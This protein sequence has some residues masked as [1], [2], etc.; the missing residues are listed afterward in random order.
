MGGATQPV[1]LRVEEPE[2]N[3]TTEAQTGNPAPTLSAV[4]HTSPPF[5][6]LEEPQAHWWHQSQGRWLKGSKSTAVSSAAHI[7]Q[8]CRGQ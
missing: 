5:H 6:P 1:E 2:I 3:A 7:P 8:E 4:S